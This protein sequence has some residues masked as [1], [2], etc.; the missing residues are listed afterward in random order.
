MIRTI[1]MPGRTFMGLAILALFALNGLWAGLAHVKPDDWYV[2]AA[3]VAG[4]VFADAA[5]GALV[6]GLLWLCS[7]GAE[8][9]QIQNPKPWIYKLAIGVYL[10]GAAI[11]A[12]VMALAIYSLCVAISE[13]SP[14]AQSATFLLAGTALFYW[15]VGRGLSYALGR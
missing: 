11:G 10:L 4:A 14:G 1:P 6:G 2:Q 15:F 12:Y 8:K 9:F 5:K 3:Y 7:K 13:P